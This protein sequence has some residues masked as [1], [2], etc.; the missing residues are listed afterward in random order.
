M[1]LIFCQKDL[2]ITTLFL[3]VVLRPPMRAENYKQ[4]ELFKDGEEIHPEVL[5]QE[6]RSGIQ[7]TNDGKITV[8]LGF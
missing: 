4:L 6:K 5:Y 7:F 1:K 2:K 8:T 3:F